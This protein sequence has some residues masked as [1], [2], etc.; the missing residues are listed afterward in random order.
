MTSFRVSDTE[1][2]CEKCGGPLREAP[3]RPY[4]V[5]TQL[6]FVASFVIFYLTYDK[7][8]EKR[9]VVLLWTALQILLGVQLVRRRLQT[10]K[11]ILRCIRCGLAVQ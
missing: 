9:A 5:F 4:P 11:R 8:H 2:P 3:A 1:K 10:R 6:A 7:I